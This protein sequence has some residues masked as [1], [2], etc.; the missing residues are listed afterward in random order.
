MKIPLNLALQPYENM[1]PL[2]LA[3]GMAAAVLVGLASLVLW[4]DWQNRDET[5]LVTEQI[6]LLQRESAALQEKQQELERWLQMP[7][8]QQIRD[9]AAFLN[10]LILRKSLSWTQIFMELEKILPAQARITAIRPSMNQLQQAELS[11]TVAAVE[12]GPLVAFLKNLESSSRFGSPVVDAQRFPTD[13]SADRNIQ[14][15]LSARYFPPDAA[16]ASPSRETEAPQ[17]AVDAA[18]LQETPQLQQ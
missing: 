8:V 7:E 15:D 10:S 4:K 6:R 1:R 17:E 3:V 18:S 5:R 13:R 16:D 14:L 12:M 2:Y 9:R 11:L